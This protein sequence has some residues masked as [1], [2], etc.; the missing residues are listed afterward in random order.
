MLLSAGAAV[1]AGGQAPPR[2]K[3][4]LE[5]ALQMAQRQNL[6]LVAARARRAIALA[7]IQI[8]RERPNPTASF[9]VLRDSPH[10]TLFFDQPLELGSKRQRRIELARA[11]GILTDVEI[12]TLERLVRRSV[13]EAFYSS[14]LARG[15][16]Q[17]KADA[18]KLA[19]R[20]HDISKA[21]FEA[22]DVPELEV[23]Q[24][25]L[26]VSRAGAEFQVAQQ[27]EKIALS[28]LDTLLNEPATTDWELVGAL[29]ALPPRAALDE[30]VGRATSSNADLQHLAQETKVEQ[31][32]QSLLKAERIPNL[33]LEFGVDFNAPP[34]FRAGPRGQITMELPIFTHNQGEIAQSSAALRALDS[35]AAATRRSVSGQVAAAYFEFEA[36][37]TEVELYN[38]TLLPAVERL[39]N[40]AEESYRAGKANIL[41][42]LDAQ[43]NVQRVHNEYLNSLFNAQA[44]FARLEEAVGVPLD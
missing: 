5:A 39:E 41:T 35:Q 44:A 20:L 15:V 7:G 2:A 19:Q 37:Q 16:S 38:K 10:E 32:R 36:R 17:Q 24:A 23:L 34:D 29:D 22:G 18:L 21:R 40:M 26:E 42:V 8:A 28:Q 9:G 1:P 43:R 13:R 12:T 4:T 14:S 3:L 6:D 25:E 30:L 31:S 33:G 11:E 27:E